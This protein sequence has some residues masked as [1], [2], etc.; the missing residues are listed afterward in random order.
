MYA[1]VKTH[2]IEHIKWV[3]FIVSYTSIK[4]IKV[5]M[6]TILAFMSLT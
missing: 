6:L 2:E 5:C 3:Q 4:L 1:S